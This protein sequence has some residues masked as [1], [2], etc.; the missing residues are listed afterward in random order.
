MKYFTILGNT[1][2]DYPHLWGFY[3]NFKISLSWWFWLGKQFHNPKKHQNRLSLEPRVWGPFGNFK[4]IELIIIV[5]ETI[6]Q[7]RKETR[8]CIL[9]F[10]GCSFENLKN[11]LSWWF[12]LGKQFHSPR[13]HNKRLGLVSF[14]MRVF[15]RFKYFELKIWLG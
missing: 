11:I 13:K 8:C 2:R 4:K 12:W 3:G 10:W 6:Q 5:R 15:W 1:K 14:F 9:F 7:I